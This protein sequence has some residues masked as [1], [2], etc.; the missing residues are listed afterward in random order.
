MN[1]KLFIRTLVQ[2]AP[3]PDGTTPVDHTIHSSGIVNSNI[4]S[5]DLEW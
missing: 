3:S 4:K 2:M 5:V 1:K